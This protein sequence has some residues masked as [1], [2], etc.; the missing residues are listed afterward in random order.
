LVVGG[1]TFVAY[2]ALTSTP[3]QSIALWMFVG[4]WGYLGL[5]FLLARIAGFRFVAAQGQPNPD[6]QILPYQFS[7][8]S[9]L[10]GTVL[11]AIPLAWCTAVLREHERTMNATSSTTKLWA[12]SFLSNSTGAQLRSASYRT[13]ILTRTQHR[14]A[15]LRA[16]FPRPLFSLS[17]I[18][19]GN[20]PRNTVVRFFWLA[21]SHRN[22]KGDNS[23][24][25]EALGGQGTARCGSLSI[26]VAMG[27]MAS[28]A[29]LLFHSSRPSPVRPTPPPL[30]E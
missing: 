12:T 7:L 30:L 19:G 23:F 4:G 22:R 15:R 5:F 13:P 16:A 11:V 26:K 2:F 20:G 21:Q 8:R 27:M 25:A 18:S 1:A 14:N 6:R 3:R 28:S 17:V 9:W 29:L 10:L 24:H